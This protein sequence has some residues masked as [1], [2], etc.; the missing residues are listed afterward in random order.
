MILIHLSNLTGLS[1]DYSKRTMGLLVSDIG[2]I[3]FGIT[4][5]M[6]TGW[7]KVGGGS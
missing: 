5:A 1:N 3:V 2:N 6:I 7:P 4:C